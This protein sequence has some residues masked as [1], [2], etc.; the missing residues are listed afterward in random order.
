MGY[1]WLILAII[2]EV[3]ATTALKASEEF[4]RLIPS[5]VV[6]IGYGIAFYLLGLVLKTVPVSIAYAIWSGSGILFITIVSALFFK[7]TPDL[8]AI[9]GMVL[10]VSG[11]VVIQLFSKSGGH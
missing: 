9:I 8:A 4:T 11:V 5:I 7:Q 6:I 1:L 3:I 2:A 10:I